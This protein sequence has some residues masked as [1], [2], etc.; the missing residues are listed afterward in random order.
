MLTNFGYISFSS[1]GVLG[2]PLNLMF[3]IFALHARECVVLI[4][5]KFLKKLSGSIKPTQLP[6][7]SFARSSFS[8]S[9]AGIVALNGLMP[10]TVARKGEVVGGLRSGAG[11]GPGGGG[12]SEFETGGA[13]GC[14]TGGGSGGS[15][16]MM[17]VNNSKRRKRTS[18][19]GALS[20]L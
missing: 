16:V 20:L 4:F 3:L 18:S 15:G 6:C 17:L 14:G 11:A 19:K 8:S 2:I 9:A 13:E 7:I 10:A 5:M 12:G 1:L